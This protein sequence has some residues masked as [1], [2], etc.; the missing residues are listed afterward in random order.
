VKR[1]Q[2]NIIQVAG[3][4]TRPVWIATLMAALM[5]KNLLPL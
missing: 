5:I 2:L 1:L 3:S 4:A